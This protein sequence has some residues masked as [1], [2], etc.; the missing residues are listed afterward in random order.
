[1]LV[2]RMD[3]LNLFQNIVTHT[4]NEKDT[5]EEDTVNTNRD[6]GGKKLHADA[7]VTKND[8]ADIILQHKDNKQISYVESNDT[9]EEIETLVSSF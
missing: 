1:M 7:S 2:S 5:S 8:E 9:L 4:S 3:S 6:L